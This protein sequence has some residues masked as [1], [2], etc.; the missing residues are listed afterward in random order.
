MV[1][2]ISIVRR[3]NHLEV[4][5]LCVGSWV[6]YIAWTFIDI[7]NKRET[8]SYVKWIICGC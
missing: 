3:W 2:K 5:L 4:N 1:G 8:R 6:R 7:I